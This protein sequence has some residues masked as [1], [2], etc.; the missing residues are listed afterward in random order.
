MLLYWLPACQHCTNNEAI[1]KA[2]GETLSTATL[3]KRRLRTWRGDKDAQSRCST[4]THVQAHMYSMY[5]WDCQTC[6]RNGG[7][8]SARIWEASA[9]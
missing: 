3:D 2:P 4:G 1:V 7:A 5:E 6:R 9:P 8:Q